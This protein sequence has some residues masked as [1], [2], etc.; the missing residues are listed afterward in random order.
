MTHMTHFPYKRPTRPVRYFSTNLRR[1]PGHRTASASCASCV[2]ARPL[3]NCGRSPTSRVTK[4]RPP[5]GGIATDNTAAIG[6][7]RLEQGPVTMTTMTNR[8]QVTV[9]L[10]ARTVGDGLVAGALIAAPKGQ[11]VY[12]VLEVWRVRRAG[13]KGCALRL[14]CSRLSRA[15]MP[16]AAEVLPWPRDPRA[17][18]GRRR[19][20]DRSRVSADPGPPEP[21]AARIARIRAKTP[22]LLEL[23]TEPIRQA[24][25]AAEA[26]QLARARRVG[27][28]LGV[29]DHSDHGPGIR[30]EAIRAHDHALLREADVT[31]ADAPDLDIP[32][33]TLR[34]ARRTDPLAVLRQVGTINAREREAG[35]MLRDAIERS[36]PSLPGVSRSEVHVAPWDRVSIS[37]R[38]LKACQCVRRAVAALDKI[39]APAVLWV[40]RD[41]GTIRGYAAFAHVRHTTVAELLRRGLGAL[42]DHYKL[43]RPRAA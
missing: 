10:R 21:P 1:P 6:R 19:V 12:R 26:V 29:V 8:D 3:R 5:F 36:E 7:G 39:V 33:V 2:M 40:V 32:N 43:T 13:D 34:R 37:E 24:K 28:H 30:L 18:R 17:P 25:A 4:S 20:A 41:G 9:T 31:V 38:Q 27:R 35:E 23:A 14:V 22:I 15:E 11:G 42:A 16:E